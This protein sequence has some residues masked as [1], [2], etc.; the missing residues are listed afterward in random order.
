[1]RKTKFTEQQVKEI[2]DELNNK[3][4]LTKLAQRY[5][6]SYQVIYCIK[7]GVTYTKFNRLSHNPITINTQMTHQRKLSHD[8]IQNI[9]AELK[10]GT[11]QLVLA[12][13]FNVSRQM[14]GNIKKRKSHVSIVSAEDIQIINSVKP[15]LTKEQIMSVKQMVQRGYKTK[16]IAEK[17]HVKTQQINYAYRGVA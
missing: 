16:F 14:I 8:D 7:N 4:N 15:R 6:T 10:C 3:A 17:F 11:T 13:K 5:N 9:V 1:M 12:K 2:V